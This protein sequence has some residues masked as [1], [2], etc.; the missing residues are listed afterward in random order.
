LI[1][2]AKALR[3]RD[4]VLARSRGIVLGN[5]PLLDAFFERWAGTFSAG[6]AKTDRP[7]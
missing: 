7:T 3:A 4:R 5:I 6:S 1:Y 2:P